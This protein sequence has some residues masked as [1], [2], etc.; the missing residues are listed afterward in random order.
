MRRLVLWTIAAL[1]LYSVVMAALEVHGSQNLA[2]QFFTD[3]EGPYP[4][5]AINTTLSVCLLWGCSLLYLVCHRVRRL[6]CTVSYDRRVLFYIA[7]TALFLALGADDRF[8]L[9]EQL[10][11]RLGIPESVIFGGLGLLEILVLFGLGHILAMDRGRKLTL[12][13]AAGFFAIMLGVDQ[14]MPGEWALRLSLED[15]AKTWSGFC[16]FLFAWQCLEHELAASSA[17][18][19]PPV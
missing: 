8:L 11:P 10:G 18:A 7:Q 1:A 15:L 13:A 6:Q 14:C 5:Y 19:N 4:F 9:H 12:M 17:L 3:I 16:L 2:R